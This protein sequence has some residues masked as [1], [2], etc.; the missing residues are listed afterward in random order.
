MVTTSHRKRMMVGF[1]GASKIEFEIKECESFS[2]LIVIAGQIT[3][4]SEYYY[5]RFAPRVLVAADAT[6]NL[7]RQQWQTTCQWI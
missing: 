6:E 2:R 3:L 4:L 1:F 7:L 5:P